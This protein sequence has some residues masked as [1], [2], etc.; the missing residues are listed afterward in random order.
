MIYVK[1][2]PLRAGTVER[3]RKEMERERYRK[4]GCFGNGM[5]MEQLRVTA[6]LVR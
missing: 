2:K 6:Y 4:E 5:D 1:C 3:E